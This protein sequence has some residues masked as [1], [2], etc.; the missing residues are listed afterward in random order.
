M[1]SHFEPCGLTQM[2]ALKYG[3]IPIVRA[4]GGLDDTVDAEV[5]FK[6]THYDGT[7]LM[8]AVREALAAYHD[9]PRWKTMMRAA[10]ARDN[11]WA[12]SAKQYDQV[13]RSLF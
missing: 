3:T 5:G 7:G 6:F 2:Y 1:P 9:G 4:T 11:S 13:Y 8:W 12:V 10:M